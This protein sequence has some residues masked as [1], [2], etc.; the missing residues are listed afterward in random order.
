MGL[1]KSLAEITQPASDEISRRVGIEPPDAPP[2]LGDV[3]RRLDLLLVE[4]RKLTDSQP[5][6]TVERV[7]YIG[8]DSGPLD[9]CQTNGYLFVSA[10]TQVRMETPVGDHVRTLYAGWNKLDYPV[11]TIIRAVVE[12]QKVMAIYRLTDVD[13]M[14]IRAVVSIA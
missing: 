11:G 10:D 3:C 14:E 4:V 8:G 13:P 5:T 9:V 1:L 6:R 7:V 12:A 2:G